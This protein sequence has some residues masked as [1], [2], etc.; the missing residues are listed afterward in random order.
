[1]K[2]AWEKYHIIYGGMP[3]QNY[4]KVLTWKRKAQDE[5]VHCKYWKKGTVNCKF[6][7]QR[8]SPLERG[9]KD[10]L[11]QSKLKKL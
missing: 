6:S 9:N 5:V 2:A 7:A 4:S 1:M 8:N 11:R 10:I 3:F